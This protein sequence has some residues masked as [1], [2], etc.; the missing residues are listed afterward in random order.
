MTDKDITKLASKLTQSLATKEDLKELATKED[1]KRLEKKIDEVDKR[2]GNKIDEVDKKASSI[3][4]FASGIDET[5]TNH[6]KRL[7][8][9]E[10]IPAVAHQIKK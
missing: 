3:M 10:Q 9:I 8:R 7:K 4:E 6:E 1:I 2:L 5:T